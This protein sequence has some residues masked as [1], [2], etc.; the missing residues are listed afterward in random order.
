MKI[1]STVTTSELN[2]AA[3][4]LAKDYQ[5][6]SLDRTNPKRI[7]FIFNEIP[8]EE[9]DSFWR[10]GNVGVSDFSKAQ[11]DLKRRIFADVY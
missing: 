8:S 5:L 2:L 7:R 9:I 1:E 10:N 4:L 3:Y 6:V 11:D